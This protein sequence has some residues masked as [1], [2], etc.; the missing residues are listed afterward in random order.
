MAIEIVVDKRLHKR[1]IKLFALI[2]VFGEI[3]FLATIL[4]VA[5]NYFK[6]QLPEF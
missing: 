6:P 5:K 3:E 2:N 4:F 1:F